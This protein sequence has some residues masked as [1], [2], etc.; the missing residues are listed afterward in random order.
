VSNRI[1]ST[2]NEVAFIAGIGTHTRNMPPRET[3]LV[4]Y[5]AALRYRH[6]WGE[7]NQREVLQ[8]LNTAIEMEAGNEKSKSV[9]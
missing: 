6:N 3:L 5:R 1:W 2:E 7:I 9:D 8:A 4:R